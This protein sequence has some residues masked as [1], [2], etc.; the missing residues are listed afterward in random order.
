MSFLNYFLRWEILTFI[1]LSILFIFLHKKFGFLGNFFHQTIIQKRD[2]KDRVSF[3][4]L[5]FAI[6]LFLILIYNYL[7]EFF[8]NFN[9]EL[10]LIFLFLAVIGY[11]LFLLGGIF[12]TQ[13][14]FYEKEIGAFATILLILFFLFKDPNSVLGR[15]MVILFGFSFLI[16]PSYFKK[17]W[18][19]KNLYPWVTFLIILIVLFSGMLLINGLYGYKNSNIELFLNMGGDSSNRYLGNGTIKCST[20]HT[21]VFV[22][23]EVEC[24]IN[25]PSNISSI[26]VTLISL[27][28]NEQKIEIENMKFKI[29][30]EISKLIFRIN[31]ISEGNK[32]IFLTT[33]SDY[34]NIIITKENSREREEK[35][36]LYFLALIGILF[37]SIPSMMKNFKNLR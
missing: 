3:S 35:F 8:R 30:Y 7:G 11:F 21:D 34:E 6:S 19:K 1:F 12:L 33:A 27:V 15:I 22:G 23:T 37:F 29:P 13:N 4:F 17:G 9:T 16:L 5:V 20:P 14:N 10:R 31:V 18:K 2:Q 24:I 28:G 25:P 26:N 32:A 36:I